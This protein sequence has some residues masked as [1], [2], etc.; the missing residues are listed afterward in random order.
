MCSSDLV[1]FVKQYAQSGLFNTSKLYQV[2]SIDAIT[3]PQQGELA[4]GTFGAQEWVNDLPNEQNKKFVDAFTDWEQACAYFGVEL[5]AEPSPPPPV[6]PETPT[7]S[8][9]SNSLREMALSI[10]DMAW[11]EVSADKSVE[12]EHP[13]PTPIPGSPP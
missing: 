1:Q 7:T 5:P 2:F 12:P 11:N 9:S 6:E 10:C 8:L 13:A 3:L 4:L